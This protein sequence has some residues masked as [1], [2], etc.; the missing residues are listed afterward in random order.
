MTGKN[1]KKLFLIL[2][3][4]ANFVSVALAEDNL[5]D[6]CAKVLKETG[7]CPED[8]CQVDCL[9]GIRYDSC[10]LSCLP[11]LCFEI[12]A[13]QCPQDYCQVVKGCSGEDVC[14]QKDSPQ[15]EDF[16]GEKGY[17]GPLGCCTGLKKVCGVK[18]FDGTCD[19]SAD[20]SAFSV[21][22]CL[23]CGDGICGHMENS[24]NCPKDCS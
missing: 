21:P 16:C 15:Q 1:M 9:L 4:F 13:G 18:T 7:Q 11:K 6:H 5:Q 23:P 8:V 20:S 19:Q 24:C 12:S 2:M 22:M 17:G 3:V 10:P 14:Y